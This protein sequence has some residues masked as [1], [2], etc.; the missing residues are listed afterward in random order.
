M[1]LENLLDSVSRMKGV[2]DV[3]PISHTR[4]RYACL[5]SSAVDC[6]ETPRVWNGV[7]DGMGSLQSE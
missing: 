5:I 7:R 1:P 6:G 2:P 3:I 4:A